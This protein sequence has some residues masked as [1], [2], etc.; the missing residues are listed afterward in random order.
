MVLC[1]DS[2]EKVRRTVA[3]RTNLP[4]DIMVEMYYDD[5][6]RIS[7]AM[8]F[9]FKSYVKLLP[10]SDSSLEDR[11][12]ELGQ[13]VEFDI[14]PDGELGTEIRKLVDDLYS[15]RNTF[16]LEKEFERYIKDHNDRNSRLTNAELD[17]QDALTIAKEA[18][19]YLGLLNNQ[20]REYYKF[21]L[22]KVVDS[23]SLME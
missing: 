12:S 22:S 4:I 11:V 16:H 5:D 17:N 23:I 6:K 9:E 20:R 21:V 13:W 7:D 14:D 10:A 19:K 1:K 2:N 3:Y 8:K 15:E 18:R